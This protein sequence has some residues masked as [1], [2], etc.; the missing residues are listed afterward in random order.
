MTI[1][2]DESAGLRYNKRMIGIGIN[3]VILRVKNN[4]LGEIW[5]IPV[6]GK[7]LEKWVAN[8]VGTP[9]QT[10]ECSPVINLAEKIK[11]VVDRT[12][13]VTVVLYCDTPLVTAKTVETAVLR[14]TEQKANAVKLPRGCVF[15]TEYLFEQESL[16]PQ[17]PAGGGEFEA[18]RDCESLS[19]IIDTIRRRILNFHAA[20]GVTIYDYHNTHIDCDVVISKGVV[21][22]P[23]NFLKGKTIIKNDVRIKPGNY[24]ENCIVGRSVTLDSSRLYDSLVGAE[25]KVGPFAYIRPNTVIGC[26]CRIGDFVELK[27]CVIG[28]GSKVSHLTY[29]GDAELGKECNVGCGVVFANYDGKNK[30]K[31]IVGNRVFIGSN[32]NIV[33]PVNIA[34]RAFIAAGSTITKEVPTQAL[35]VARARQT[36]IPN[37]QGN[38]YAPPSEAGDSARSFKFVSYSDGII[39]AAATEEHNTPQEQTD[40]SVAQDGAESD[41]H[42]FNGTMPE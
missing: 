33:A 11:S 2:V 6:L 23:Y 10:I 31:S 7:T 4:T 22:E 26:G 9:C 24:I 20:N 28:D 17:E 32:A 25:T 12:K 38:N 35:A 30:F 18:V 5:N 34:D 27:N 36:L 8:T 40:G 13:P 29:I 39:D 41:E 42:G 15:R 14:L 21:I 16:F 37:W 1:K 19:R 3:G